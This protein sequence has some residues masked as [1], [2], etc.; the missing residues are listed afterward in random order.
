MQLTIGK[1]L[2][3]NDKIYKPD[4]NSKSGRELLAFYLQTKFRQIFVYDKKQENPILNGVNP[5]FVDRFSKRLINNPTKRLL[6][7]V[8]GESAS[9]KSTICREIKSVIEQFSM[10]VTVLSTDNYFNDISELINKY[11]S[12]DN[13]TDNG[14]DVDAPSSFQLD[15]LREDLE[16][17]SE[18]LDI[19]APMYLPNGTGVSV[20]KA[21]DV[22]SQKIIVVEGIATMYDAVKDIFDIKIYV[23]TEN[24][25]R[26]NRFMDRAV[27][28][29]NQSVENAQ[30]HWDYITQAGEKYVK[31]FR[32]EADL[33]INGNSDLKY[34]AQ[35]LEHIYEITNNYEQA[36]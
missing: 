29:R 21:F 14:Y 26:K 33:V 5:T 6:I 4:F 9:G 36:P 2:N 27:E 32:K 30:K 28:E 13:L 3:A 1:E 24:E 25:L 34:F 11:G 22:K 31:P 23:E 20:P 16:D 35:M 12:F 10:P 19:K 7:G 8:T 17:L 15:I 18:G